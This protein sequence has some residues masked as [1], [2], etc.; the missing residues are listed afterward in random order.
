MKFFVV[1]PY[2]R[3]KAIESTVVAEVATADEAFAEIDRLA[4]RMQRTGAPSDYIELIVVD[5]QRRIVPRRVS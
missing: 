1:Q 5:E 4:E 2:G 3:H